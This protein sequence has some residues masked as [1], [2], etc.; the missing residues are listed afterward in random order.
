MVILIDA[1]ILLNYFFHRDPGYKYA[2]FILQKCADNA[3]SGYIAFHS[4]SIIWYML[5]KLPDVE[6][7]NIL[8]QLLTIVK[9]TCTSHDEVQRALDRVDFKDFEDCL[10]DLCAIGVTADFLVTDSIKDLSHATSKVV[11]SEAFYS[12]FA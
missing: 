5:R 9:V 12:Q 8:R 7:R 4:V 1:N 6:R 3:V 10:Q 2:E 11:S